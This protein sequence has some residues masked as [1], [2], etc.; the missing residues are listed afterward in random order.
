MWF[1]TGGKTDGPQYGRCTS[2]QCAWRHIVHCVSHPI[3]TYE[4]RL[5]VKE[6]V[7][8]HAVAERVGFVDEW[9]ISGA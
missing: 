9:R 1:N 5:K 7:E 8:I 3:H 4:I 2:V 6:N